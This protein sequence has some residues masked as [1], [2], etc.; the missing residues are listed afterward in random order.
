[1]RTVRASQRNV[2]SRPKSF[3]YEKLSGFS[4]FFANSI[5]CMTNNSAFGASI[6]QIWPLSILLITSLTLFLINC[7]LLV[8]LLIY[9]KLEHNGIIAHKWFADYLSNRKQYTTVKKCDSSR[10]TVN[11]GVPQ[12]SILGPLL[13]LLYVNGLHCCS[14]LLSF[15]LFADDTTILFSH[16]SLASLVN[17]LNSELV[18]VSSWFQANKLF[19]NSTK[20]KYIVFSRSMNLNNLYEPVMIN[21]TPISKVHFTKILGVCIIDDKLS[22]RHHIASV[23]ISLAET[24][25]YSPSSAHSF[26]APPFSRCINTLILPYLNYCN[27]VWARTSTNKLQSLIKVQKKAIRICTLSHPRDH[28]APLFAKLRTLTL[29]DIN[30]FQAG[31]LMYKKKNSSPHLLIVHITPGLTK[32][33]MYNSLARHLQWT[34][35]ANFMDLFSGM[36]LTRLSNL[37]PL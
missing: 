36:D 34:P 17:I 32:T 3:C 15:I 22:W 13:F 33:C 26:H 12:G 23:S 29:V 11:H 37:N 9:Q 21:D 35:C 8:D 25:V 5:F 16:P 4:I 14:T 27:I 2:H 10:M 7:T 30:K 19:L 6:L 18:N 24:R 20:T 1:M 31:I 28:T